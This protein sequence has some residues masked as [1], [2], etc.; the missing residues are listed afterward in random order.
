MDSP[1]HYPKAKHR[2]TRTPPVYSDYRNYKPELRLEFSGQ[3]V[4][5]RAVDANRQES[6]GVDH[7]RPKSIPKFRSLTTNY[8]NLFYA[9]NRCN[10]YKRA[11]WPSPSEMKAGVFVPN[12]CD[13]VMWEHLRSR[14]DGAVTTASKAGEFTS[15]LLL[16]NETEAVA[17]RRSLT[18]VLGTL[19]AQIAVARKTIQEA[20]RCVAREKTPEGKSRA[21]A[22]HIRAEANL[23]Q[24]QAAIPG[25]LGL[26]APALR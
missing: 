9:C 6:F 22:Q 14:S 23:H 13:H 20:K 5:C 8:L 25:L 15:D 17:Y 24:L 16:L 2:R 4:Y 12:P 7:Y 3:C 19:A 18:T 26:A 1:F 11:F 10:S 21:D